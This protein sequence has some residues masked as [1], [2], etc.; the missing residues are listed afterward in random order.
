MK[1]GDK[2]VV[3]IIDIGVN[4]EG[5]AKQS[6]FIIFVPYTLVGETVE[7]EIYKTKNNIAFANAIK[8]IKTSPERITPICPV[9]TICGGCDYQHTNYQHQF[10]LKTKAVKTTL[11]KMLG[12]SVA[13]NG[14]IAS[15]QNF[16]YRNK[17]ELPVANGQ[18]GF[19]KWNTNEIVP[20]KACPLCGEWLRKL[21]KL[22]NE[23]IAEFNISTY[24]S[25]TKKGNIKHLV[26]RYFDDC[27]TLV[28]VTTSKEFSH[29]KELINRL[30]ENF[31]KVNLFQNINAKYNGEVMSSDFVLLLGE[32]VQKSYD[33]SVRYEVSPYS[34]LQ[35]NRD[36]QN[37]VYQNILDNIDKNAVVVDAFSGAGLLTAILSKKSEKVYGIE[38]NKDATKNANEL[39][40]QN[41]ITNVENINGDCGLE[42]PKLVEKLRTAGKNN[43]NVIL[44][45]PRKGVSKS[46][47]DALLK[48]LPNKIISLSCNP[49]TLARDLKLLFANYNIQSIQPYDMFPQTKHIET[50]VCLVKKF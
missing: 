25:Q 46:V 30:N 27:L 39:I 20:I 3:E 44:D 21:L 45:P 47:V 19:Y 41:N 32:K 16:A 24:N 43:I 34:F 42:L 28:V 23:F 35:V 40:K 1:I 9:Y 13:V 10:E 6:D 2:L 36:I 49:A 14:C 7:V 29:K 8:I 38:I 33:L 48:S 18:V 37:L 31:A 26:A 50:L 5:V 12:N 22:F 4:G 15:P 17:V 11:T